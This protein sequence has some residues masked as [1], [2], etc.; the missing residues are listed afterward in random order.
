MRRMHHFALEWAAQGLTTLVEIER[1]LGRDAVGDEKPEAAG[2]TRILLV[3]DDDDALTMMLELLKR[4][5]Y[6]VEVEVDGQGA[7][8]RLGRDPHF[9]IVILDLQ[10]PGL[11]GQDMLRRI[12]GAVDAA[13][14]PVLVRTGTRGESREAEL[15][16]AGADDYVTKSAS[17]E[18]FLARVRAVLRRAAL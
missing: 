18:R 4:E 2:P 12:R 9:S 1:V 14:L 3:E 10:L 15:L 13:A 6:E 17:A 7:V 8:D 16:E 11:D 5:G